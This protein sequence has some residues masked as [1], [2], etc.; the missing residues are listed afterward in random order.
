MPRRGRLSLIISLRRCGFASVRAQHG[1]SKDGVGLWNW[2][3]FADVIHFADDL[4][5]FSPLWIDFKV[6]LRLEFEYSKNRSQRNVSCDG[7]TRTD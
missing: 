7:N 1:T 6:S 5:S 4:F 3:G 2:Q